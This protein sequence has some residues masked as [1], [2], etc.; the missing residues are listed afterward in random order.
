LPYHIQQ[1]Q[2]LFVL[3]VEAVPKDNGA[4]DIGDCSAHEEGGVYAGACE[5][6][7][8]K[9]EKGIEE[10]RINWTVRCQSEHLRRTLQ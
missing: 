3:I 6:G 1:R 2:E 9:K 8:G 5:V 7:P 10:E 4:N